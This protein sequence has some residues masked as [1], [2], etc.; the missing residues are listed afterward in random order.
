MA[1]NPRATS[2]DARDADL[3]R[4]VFSL[5]RVGFSIVE[6]VDPEDPDTW[7]IRANNAAASE[8]SQADVSQ[9]VGQP[10]LVAFP[11][12]RET[13]FIDWYREVARTGD[14]MELPELRYGDDNV[15]DA[16][17]RV[18]LQPLPARCVLGQYVNVTLQR[19]AEGRLRALNA[20]LERQVQRRTAE[21]RA[22]KQTISEIAYAAA[23][24]LQTPLRH[25]LL[26]S[27][28]DDF[29]ETPP[30]VELAHLEQI[31]R[32]AVAI[33]KRLSALLTYTE[34]ERMEAPTTV[35]A[36]AIIRALLADLEDEGLLGDAVCTLAAT[37]DHPLSLAVDAL[38]ITAREY[39]VNALTFCTPGRPP[40]VSIRL[41]RDEPGTLLLS[42]QDNGRGIAPKY[43]ESVFHAFYR[44]AATGDRDGVGVGLA[45][46]RVAVAAAG[47]QLG[48]RSEDGEGSTFW[49]RFP[50]HT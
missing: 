43:H 41:D 29:D 47:G 28:P 8:A 16:A 20:S 42:V 3:Y 6:L 4:A 13:P 39:I 22:S 9:Y 25:V 21:L 5:A 23:H 7:L 18:W 26:L 49:A 44:L 34:A 33:K 38:R 30:Q 2:A 40:R 36:G 19:R 15:P 17:Y 48:L 27:E 50:I 32:A 14:E 45:R 10:L 35:D 11:M 46:T 24:D 31:H 37:P 1:A 12:L